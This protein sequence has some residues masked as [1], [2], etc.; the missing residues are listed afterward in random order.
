MIATDCLAV[1]KLHRLKPRTKV[2]HLLAAATILLAPVSITSCSSIPKQTATVDAQITVAITDP[3]FQKIVSV[4]EL[5]T[6]KGSGSLK[7]GK[8]K[9]KNQTIEVEEGTTF[10][11]DA[12]IGFD[13]KP[14]VDT[15][16]AKGVLTLNKEIKLDNVPL[17]TRVQLENGKATVELDIARAL[18]AALINALQ[19]HHSDGK[20]NAPLADLPSSIEIKEARLDLKE[21]SVFEFA[22]CSADIGKGS[23]IKLANVVVASKTKYAGSMSVDFKLN[24]NT[25]FTSN[26]MTCGISNGRIQFAANIECEE[27]KLKIVSVADNNSCTLSASNCVFHSVE[28]NVKTSSESKTNNSPKTVSDK[29]TVTTKEVNINIDKL[30]IAKTLDV[31]DAPSVNFSGRAELK[32]TDFDVA[33]APHSI[34]GSIPSSSAVKVDYTSTAQ[35]TSGAV[36]IDQGITAQNFRWTANMAGDYLDVQ[37]REA[38]IAHV[39]ADTTSGIALKLDAAIKPSKLTWKG[40]HAALDLTFDKE[41]RVSSAE[42]MSFSFHNS[43]V[44]TPK[45]LPLDIAAGNVSIRD[46]KNHVFKLKNVD[47]NCK[48]SV[49]EKTMKVDCDASM[50]LSS[51]ADVLGIPGFNAKIGKLKISATEQHAQLQLLDCLVLLSMNDL[52]KSI[53]EKLPDPLVVQKE[54]VLLEKK[55]LRYRNLR[56]KKITVSHPSLTDFSFQK[57]NEVSVAADADLKLEGTVEVYHQKL[58]PLSKVPSSWKEHPWEASAHV[59]EDGLVD[60]K[61]VSGKSLKD[62]KIHLDTKLQIGYP[63]KISVDWSK[64]AG[65]TLA[66]AEN[67]V[68]Q[69][70]ISGA[71]LFAK[72]KTIAVNY[73]GD[74]AVFKSAD[75]RLNAIQVKSLTMSPRGND[76]AINFS[77]LARF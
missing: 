58:N 18:F 20:D 21:G 30:E 44:T 60:Y 62:S 76:L 4:C 5:L 63:D 75:A 68:L 47:G 25:S 27:G 31:T 36:V 49:G 3:L 6:I 61:L 48:I 57:A 24:K 54:E 33:I 64:V 19:Q 46:K 9:F 16:L 45:S 34:K 39:K 10:E 29:T 14:A 1:K 65:D 23:S 11:L 73:S 12:S 71:K 15:G 2:V 7:A 66:K 28:Q 69:T 56:I 51:N 74:L 43:K 17:P 50:R 70:A 55:Q 37:L 40:P 13:G 52:K 77:A 38:T 8:Y 59:K 32:G 53:T 41:A 35:K 42:P 22:G 72:D 67:K 26:G